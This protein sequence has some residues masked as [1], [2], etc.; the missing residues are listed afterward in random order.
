MAYEKLLLNPKPKRYLP[1]EF[2]NPGIS[3][4]KATVESATSNDFKFERSA[5]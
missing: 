3:G 1:Q 4:L 5:A 2:G